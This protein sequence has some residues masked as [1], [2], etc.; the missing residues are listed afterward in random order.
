[1]GTLNYAGRALLSTSLECMLRSLELEIFRRTS[2]GNSVLVEI[3]A[4]EDRHEALSLHVSAG[5]PLYFTYTEG[6]GHGPNPEYSEV[7][8]K[9]PQDSPLWFPS[10]YFVNRI[11]E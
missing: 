3:G 4:G 9:V 10:Q 8:S 7:L 6:K 5:T 1:M 2:T 11:V